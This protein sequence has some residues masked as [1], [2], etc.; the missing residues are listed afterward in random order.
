MKKCTLDQCIHI[1]NGICTEEKTIYS[2]GR[3]KTYETYEH[4]MGT[5]NP[6]CYKSRKYRSIL[7]EAL[8]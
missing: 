6:H 1:K 4:M 5:F 7:I 8:K 2:Y 3:C